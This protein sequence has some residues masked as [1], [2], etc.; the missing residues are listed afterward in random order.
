MACQ[1]YW[2]TRFAYFFSLKLHASL[3]P[4]SKSAPHSVKYKMMGRE[5]E[6]EH[7][8]HRSIAARKIFNPFLLSH[9]DFWW[10]I[11]FFG[12]Y[13]ALF[14]LISLHFIIFLKIPLLTSS[15]SGVAESRE[16]ENN[17]MWWGR[18]VKNISF[19]TLFDFL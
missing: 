6:K 17:S 1:I 15:L 8:S 12:L 11:F 7:Y 14:I 5:R 13:S 10:K 2:A 9:F 4:P 19:F 16:K 18:R 3:L